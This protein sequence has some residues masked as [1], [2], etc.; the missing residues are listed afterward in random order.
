ME[1]PEDYFQSYCKILDKLK[2][3]YSKMIANF[4]LFEKTILNNRN[5]LIRKP[6]YAEA[7]DSLNQLITHLKRQKPNHIYAALCFL[8]VARYEQANKANVLSAGAYVEAGVKLRN[9]LEHNLFF[10]LGYTFFSSE[11][12][13]NEFNFVGFEE[14]LVEATNC[15]VYAIKV[16]I[17]PSLRFF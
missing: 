2:K 13:S 5:L 15:Y 16:W 11:S 14:D 17:L 9:F 8:A 3:R 7:V 4:H 6:N 10:P 12:E 1:K